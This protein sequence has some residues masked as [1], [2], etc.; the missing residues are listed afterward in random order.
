MS[1]FQNILL[2]RT[3][4]CMRCGIGVACK[5]GTEQDTPTGEST[6]EA[7][8]NSKPCRDSRQLNSSLSSHANK[9]IGL[10]RE[11]W[12]CSR[13]HASRPSEKPQPHATGCICCELKAA[14]QARRTSRLAGLRHVSPSTITWPLREYLP[15]LGTQILLE[16]R[17][18][19]GFF[20]R[21]ALMTLR[22]G[23]P[24]SERGPVLVHCA[25]FCQPSPASIDYFK[26][27]CFFS[28]N[29]RWTFIY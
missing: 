27:G 25:H 17:H 3:W 7:P 18:I 15:T 1:S 10:S 28:R 2:Q 24:G 4:E 11:P 26:A 23:A 8:Y 5:T 12:H 19:K 22:K 20:L 21:S 29:R 14:N 6:S 9:N 16:A 13:H